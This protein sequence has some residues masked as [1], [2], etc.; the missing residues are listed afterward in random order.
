[1]L[2]PLEPDEIGRLGGYRVLSLLAQGAMALV[3][4][5]E[6]AALRRRVAL[7]VMKPD[8]RDD[9]DAAQRFLR[10]ARIMA[11]TE[12]QHLVR[13]FQVGQEEG[14]VYLALEL[15]EGQT[16]EGWSAGIGKA[17]AL[18]IVRVGREIAA[19]LAVIHQKGL[20]HRDIK[21]SNLWLEA[22]GQRVKILDFGLARYASDANFTRAGMIVGTPA[23]MSP[24]QG[25]GERVDAR[26][27]L[28]SLGGVLNYLCTGIQPFPGENI[29]AVLSALALLEPRPP[30]ELNPALPGALSALIMRLLAK[31]PEDR[32]ASAEAVIEQLRQIEA[33]LANGTERLEPGAVSCA[34]PAAV[35]GAGRRRRA[36]VPGRS[37]VK[38]TLAV[39]LLLS[40]GTFAWLTVLPALVGWGPRRTWAEPRAPG[41]VYLTEM[42]PIAIEEWIKQPPPPRE[43]DPHGKRPPPPFKGVR[44]HGALSPHGIFMHPPLSPEGGTSWLRYRLDRRYGTF[45]AEVSLNDGPP[46]CDTPLTFSVHADGQLL[47][48]SDEV[49]SQAD[50][51]RCRVSVKGVEVLTIEV[52]CPGEPR[53]AHAVW[54]EPSVTP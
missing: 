47:W 8:L 28:F 18:D 12:H 24:E 42:K 49:Q 52:H 38:W 41:Q 2:P 50:T 31:C 51:Q 22:P 23:F 36:L 16:L 15:L 9:V 13:V 43:D 6:D 35:A 7:K 1:L 46:R 17:P 34:L 33:D 19:G 48:Q 30:H 5:A 25:R 45:Q 11:A 3:F 44:V 26:G 37:W 53:G 21:P 54:I 14:V 27:D 4:L 40:L 29:M 32:P 39:V 20:V 10:E